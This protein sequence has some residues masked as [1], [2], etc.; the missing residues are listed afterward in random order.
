MT[1]DWHSMHDGVTLETVENGGSVAYD[2]VGAPVATLAFELD[3]LP[4]GATAALDCVLTADGPLGPWTAAAGVARVAR[5]PPK[6]NAVKV[7]TRLRTV[8]VNDAPYLPFGFYLEYDRWQTGAANFSRA[9]Y[10]EVVNGFNT[11]LPYRCGCWRTAR[12]VAA[13]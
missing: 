7:N 5:H 10:A 11:P 12:S 3:T 2:A 13:R 4:M 1:G 8:L 6:A 9:M